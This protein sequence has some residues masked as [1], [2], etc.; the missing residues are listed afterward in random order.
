[1][2]RNETGRGFQETD[3][4]NGVE[5]KVGDLYNQ[6]L[7]Q[8]CV[9]YSTLIDFRKRPRW[10]GDLGTPEDFLEA[11]VLLADSD[12]VLALVQQ[13]QAEKERMQAELD[14]AR[15]PHQKLRQLRK[16]AREEQQAEG[17]DVGQS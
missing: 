8:L 4:G 14:E 3:D 15:L 10:F 2:S 16:Q 1:M 6:M 7:D 11:L 17:M 13:R 9:M 5:D 12:V